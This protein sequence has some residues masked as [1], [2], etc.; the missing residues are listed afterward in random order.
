[1]QQNG[2]NSL[3]QT[4]LRPANQCRLQLVPVVPARAAELLNVL[5]FSAAV[6]CHGLPG[7]ILLMTLS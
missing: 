4:L 2:E 1:M 5:Q 6:V 7:P 3:R